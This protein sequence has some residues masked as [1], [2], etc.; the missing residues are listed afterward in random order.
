MYWCYLIFFFHF[1]FLFFLFCSLFLWWIKNTANV[2]P[3]FHGSICVTHFCQSTGVDMVTWLLSRAI[4][5]AVWPILRG[6]KVDFCEF[7]LNLHTLKYYSKFICGLG[8]C[9]YPWGVP[10]FFRFLFF[11]PTSSH[12]HLI[13]KNILSNFRWCEITFVVL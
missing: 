2:L 9:W 3:W 6:F 5:K 8:V 11:I 1:M 10:S 13:P 12:T 4:H 7:S